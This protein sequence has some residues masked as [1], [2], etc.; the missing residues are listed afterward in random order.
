MEI[1]QPSDPFVDDGLMVTY[2][3]RGPFAPQTTNS[4][5]LRKTFEKESNVMGTQLRGS[6]K[7]DTKDIFQLKKLVKF[8]ITST[9]TFGSEI[10]YI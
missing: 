6:G 10:K 5:P 4:E 7:H 8:T 1:S 9:P 3:H 2:E